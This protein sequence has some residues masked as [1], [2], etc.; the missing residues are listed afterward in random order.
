MKITR[1]AMSALLA[2]VGLACLTTG[3][4]AQEDKVTGADPKTW[5]ASVDKA[6]AFLR[7]AQEPNGSWGSSRSPGITGIVVTGLLRTGKVSPSDPM[8]EKALKYIES[9]IN[10]RAGHIAG[11]DPRVQLQNY[12]TCINVMALIEAN[13]DSYKTVIG[14]ATKF[15]K[16][17]QWDEGENVKPEN[18][19]YGGAGYNSASRPDL[20]NMQFML[21][22]LV[23]AGVPKDDP[24]F[25]KALVF[26]SRCQNI[27]G[28]ENDQ[29]WAGK[30]DDGSFIYTPAAGGSTKVQDEPLA[31]GGLPGYGSMTY[32][33]IKSLIYCGV[34]KN[35]PRLKKALEWVQ[36]NY[37]LDR[38]PGMPQVRAQWGLYYYYHTMAKC[39]SVV[40]E[41]VLVD[42]DGKKHDWRAEMTEALAKRQKGDGSWIN[43]QDRW[44]EGDPQIVT[45]YALMALSYCKPK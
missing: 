25:K 45:G 42:A 26:V 6:I 18:D 23:A 39:L 19:Y 8:I 1:W 7:A 41:D 11:Q 40:G 21:D 17:L 33:G 30:I 9:L 34:D 12:V 10:P 36:K 13:R 15:L 5:N 14:D 4:S 37:T 22:T 3:L 29:A 16:Q 35:D 32:A 2:T 31:N 27:K 28:E 38:N 43:E 20:S 44:M 24:A